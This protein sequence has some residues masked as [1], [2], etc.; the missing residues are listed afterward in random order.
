MVFVFYLLLPLSFFS[1]FASAVFRNYYIC[2]W[3]KN[4]ILF[5]KF[6]LN[7]KKC[8]DFYIKIEFDGKFR[9]KCIFEFIRTHTYIQTQ[10]TN[11]PYFFI[12]L[13]FY[14]GSK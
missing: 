3:Q 14:R 2:F 6:Q 12:Y 7:A 5:E 8:N 11:Y 13:F 10:A 1:I 9:M 4:S